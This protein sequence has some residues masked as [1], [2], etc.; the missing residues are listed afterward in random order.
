MLPRGAAAGAEARQ[1]RR[2]G[3]PHLRIRLPH[4]GDGRRDVEIVQP[5]LFDQRVQFAASETPATSPRTAIRRSR[6]PESR[7]TLPG[8]PGL[9]ACSRARCRSQPATRRHPG[10]REPNVLERFSKIASWGP[11]VGSTGNPIDLAGFC[12][13]AVSVRPAPARLAEFGL[14]A[15]PPTPD[16]APTSANRTRPRRNRPISAFRAAGGLAP[17]HGICKTPAHTGN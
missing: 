10:S 15:T 8:C 6:F 9:A 14:A 17:T 7:D 13:G 12:N 11:A 1:Q 3:D 16:A 5:R 2:A 4:P